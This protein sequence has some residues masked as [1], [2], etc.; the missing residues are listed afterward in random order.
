MITLH[1]F[2]AKCTF[3]VWSCTHRCIWTASKQYA[4]SSWLLAK[5]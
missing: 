3:S 1:W 2:W 5:P 4:F